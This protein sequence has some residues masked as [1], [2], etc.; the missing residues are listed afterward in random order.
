[1]PSIFQLDA[2]PRWMT[3]SRVQSKTRPW[4]G[5]GTVEDDG[6]IQWADGLLSRQTKHDLTTLEL[7][8]APTAP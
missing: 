2:P 1:M 6:R 5:T 3:G 4:W 7:D 8:E